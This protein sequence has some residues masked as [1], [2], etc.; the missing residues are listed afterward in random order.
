MNGFTC[1]TDS[2]FPRT[3]ALSREF[4]ARQRLPQNV[5]ERSVPGEED[6]AGLA[7]LASL[8]GH[9]ETDESLARSGNACDKDDRLGARG[10]S[11]RR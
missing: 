4:V 8:R 11:A 2:A 7:I 3:V 1:L 5:D 9:V 6:G 10:A